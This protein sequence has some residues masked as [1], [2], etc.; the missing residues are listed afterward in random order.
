MN[1]SIHIRYEN[2]SKCYYL[3]ATIKKGEAYVQ[4]YKGLCNLHA[5]INLSLTFFDGNITTNVLT[6]DIFTGLKVQ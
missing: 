1:N 2:K 5:L 6:S 3:F 4:V